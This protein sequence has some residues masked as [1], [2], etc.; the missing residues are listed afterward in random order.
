M[1]L[2]ELA[3]SCHVVAKKVS[4]QVDTLVVCN[5]GSGQLGLVCYIKEATQPFLGMLLTRGSF[6]FLCL[7]NFCGVHLEFTIM[8][9]MAS[10]HSCHL[11]LLASVDNCSC[12]RLFPFT[13]T[14]PLIGRVGGLPSNIADTSCEVLI[15]E[16]TAVA[17]GHV[18]LHSLLLVYVVPLFGIRNR[19]HCVALFRQQSRGG[20]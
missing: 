14:A 6:R 20:T 19:W 12:Q 17:V 13:S 3:T 2:D 10:S 4:C 11:A 18:I 8:V 7:S 9:Y 1:V 15:V 16:C 5:T